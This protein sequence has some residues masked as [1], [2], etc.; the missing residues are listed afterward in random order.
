MPFRVKNISKY[1]FSLLGNIVD[2]YDDIDLLEYYSPTFIKN[3]LLNGELYNKL[4][5]RMFALVS[6]G[7]DYEE[8][9]LTE[10][11]F[12]R[13]VYV[14]FLQGKLG[15][16][17]LKPPLTFDST[18]S[19]LVRISGGSSDGYELI[20]L[21]DQVDFPADTYSYYVD[22]IGWRYLGIWMRTGA[23]TTSKV[24]CS[25]EFDAE[26]DAANYADIT[27]KLFGVSTLAAS[28]THLLNVDTP[29]LFRWLRIDINITAT[30]N[31]CGIWIQ[32]LTAV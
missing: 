5:G 32:K 30:P 11:E 15:Q 7:I 12:D 9:D 4:M 18:G 29:F 16:E 22:M 28:N 20:K 26:S 6:P 19:L 10:E 23:N 1:E 21:V 14:G 25:G 24:Y 17:D 2:P 31:S 27:L 13:L 3:S 8:L